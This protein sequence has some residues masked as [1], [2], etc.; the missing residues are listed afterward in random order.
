MKYGELVD[1]DPIETVIVLR[2]ADAVTEAK[3]L[4]ETYV[5]SEDMAKKLTGIVFPHLQFKRPYDSKGLLIVGNYGT[6]KS[7]LMALITAIAEHEDLVQYARNEE[8]A[9]KAGEIAGCFKV[10]R[11]EI[12]ATKMSLR[13]IV[14]S[15]LGRGLKE[16]G[17]DY[18]FPSLEEVTGTKG[19]FQEMMAE[20]SEKYPEKGLLFALDELLD[21]LR[22]RRG[23]DLVLDLNFMRE[24][25]ESCKESRFRFMA[26][27]QE[28]LFENPRLQFVASSV[29]R[30]K[31]RY[32]EIYISTQ[33][34]EYVISERLLKKNN[35]QKSLIR[36]HLE[37]FTG[38]Y[39]GL[40][41]QINHYVDLFPVHPAYI[42]TFE[43]ISFAEK[44]EI[45][46][47]F[48]NSIGK[49]L[50]EEVPGDQPGLL[51]YDSY[52]NYIK[53]DPSFRGIPEVGKVIKTSNKL[54]NKLETLSP[55]NYR[56]IAI[57][58][59]HALSIHRLTTATIEDPIGT[60]SEELRDQLCV[61]FPI[62]VPEPQRTEDFLK[63]T[64]DMIFSKI[65]KTV[66]GQYI[67]YNEDSG[68]YY[69]D[70]EKDI[71]YDTLIRE[72]GDGLN[73]GQLD[74]YYFNVLASLM[75]CADTTYIS[76]FKIWEHELAWVDHGSTRRGYLFF[77]PPNKR[78]T[79]QPP[80]DFYI[81]FLPIFEE[82]QFEDEKKKDEVFY[83][84]TEQPEDLRQ[85]IRLYGGA[86]ELA[87]GAIKSQ[88]KE[89]LDKAE[90][91]LSKATE[92]LYKNAISAFQLSYQG[93]M[94]ALHTYLSLQHAHPT[95]RELIDLGAS[96]CLAPYIEELSP[97]YPKFSVPLTEGNRGEATRE[98]LRYLGGG[99][100]TKLGAAVLDG[101]ELLEGEFIR[102]EKSKYARHVLSLLKGKKKGQVLNRRELIEDLHGVEFEARFRLEP[103]LLV[104]VF[105][106]L[107]RDGQIILSIVG[108]KFSATNFDEFMK[109]SVDD[110][111]GF[112]HIERPKEVPVGTL[113]LLFEILELPPGLV[114]STD[115]FDE[116]VV[117]LQEKVGVRVRDLVEIQHKAKDG[118]VLWNAPLISEAEL[119]ETR[120][121]LAELKTFL[122]SLQ[123]Y[124]SPGRLRNFRYSLT[125]VED[126]RDRFKL[127]ADTKSLVSLVEDINPLVNY[128]ST[129]EALLPAS[130]QWISNLKEE[131]KSLITRLLDHDTRIQPDF[132][133]ELRKQLESLKT[134]Y[135]NEYMT[136][137]NRARLNAIFDSM[138]AQLVKDDRLR[139]LNQ[140]AQI[141][142]LPRNRLSSFQ[143][144]LSSLG[145]CFNLAKQELET[146]PICP[147]CNYRPIEEPMKGAASDI[148]NEL[149]KDLDT[150]QGE[151]EQILLGNLSEPMVKE[152]ISLLKPEEREPVEK[153]LTNFKLPEKISDSLVRVLGDVLSGLDKVEVTAMKL[154][155]DFTEGGMPCTVEEYR[156]RFEGHLEKLVR[157]K[158]QSKIR[159]MI[160]K[161]G[162]D[163]SK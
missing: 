4:V 153:V 88:K 62:E 51:T 89:C 152:N 154:I 46:K 30:V 118:L 54:E 102:P 90:S 85:N 36:S 117:K 23:Q 119:D 111:T 103:E 109:T 161:K 125:D 32:E 95:F 101:L 112:K 135:I 151:W 78:S 38:L 22:T 24:I 94:N 5:I 73:D 65:M 67:S 159:I 17:V 84:L 18:K 35:R 39:G 20:F 74:R 122:E 137:H 19:L 91:Y 106:A 98:A 16:L 2:K 93:T 61:S 37:R 138:K 80:R 113:R 52:W 86:T 160:E 96:K 33:D 43:R 150:I 9:E 92:W 11:A 148:L 124:N 130:H 31:T 144:R 79:A 10:I 121:E 147:H 143:N 55:V 53:K 145:T 41:E 66:S 136:L 3:R 45:L 59:I 77:G 47:T 120:R 70:L 99:S 40:N 163:A 28:T 116:A 49:I 13:D 126:Q 100:K 57:Q 129:S 48:S 42:K 25:G 140:L 27:I 115:T 108:K 34:V 132:K 75:G 133:D 123:V 134:G 1:F 7:H 71:D 104:V 60:T 8:V 128:L 69:L 6:G 87:S 50:E 26:G 83:R 82:V 21:Y 158:D 162:G 64:I 131:K 56:M 58:L 157:G 146:S 97:E 14:L 155:G 29:R 114:S 12:G 63:T 68:Q 107:V 142:L 141:D 127:F 110:L 81:Y 139:R 72:K 15:E 149:D 156:R 76:G 44:R 105:G